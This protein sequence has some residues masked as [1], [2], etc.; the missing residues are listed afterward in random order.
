MRD[1]AFSDVADLYD[2]W[3]A[4]AMPDDPQA[5]A[6]ATLEDV[7]QEQEAQIAVLRQALAASAHDYA[8]SV[9]TVATLR[10]EVASLRRETP[11][12]WET[13]GATVLC[14]LYDLQAHWRHHARG[15]AFVL[16]CA[17]L[18]WA[19]ALFGPGGR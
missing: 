17:G 6:L 12:W 10:R 14:G 2:A 19:V 18:V 11:H 13:L 16:A 1:L 8:G 7:V 9:A 4:Q 5:F 15:I 3:D